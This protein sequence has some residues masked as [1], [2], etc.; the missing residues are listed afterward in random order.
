MIHTSMT[1]S[2]RFSGVA[3]HW[4]SGATRRSWRRRRRRRRDD[5]EEHCILDAR[6]APP[7]RRERVRDIALADVALRGLHV[8]ARHA[9]RQGVV[10]RLAGVMRV[11][12]G[13]ERLGVPVAL[14]DKVNLC[15]GT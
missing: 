6:V 2:P 12:Q 8:E 13:G 4:L 11:D 1:Y 10:R 14:L 15:G 5:D 7:R 9:G 3:I